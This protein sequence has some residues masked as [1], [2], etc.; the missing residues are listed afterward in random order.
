MGPCRALRAARLLAAYDD[1]DDDVS[2]DVNE[3]GIDESNVSDEDE[4]D[5]DDDGDGCG[6]GSKAGRPVVRQKRLYC[7]HDEHSDLVRLAAFR[8]KAAPPGGFADLAL[9]LPDRQMLRLTST[10]P[11][12]E[13]DDY[14]LHL[15]EALSF[16]RHYSCR[17]V[18]GDL[19]LPPA[20]PRAPSPC[21]RLHRGRLWPVL[22]DSDASSSSSSS[23][24]SRSSGSPES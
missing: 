12:C 3:S 24:S 16:L 1:D 17:Q 7:V 15:R 9:S 4:S 10:S 23:S 20:P 13:E 2:D 11:E 19:L 22:S 14:C 5:G 18:F 8:Y 6:G 21:R